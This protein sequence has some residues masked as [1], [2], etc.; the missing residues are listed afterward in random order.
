MDGF[1]EQYISSNTLALI[2]SSLIFIIT[3]TLVTKQLINFV[4]TCVLLFFAVVSGMAIANNDIVR[5]Y[6]GWEPAAAKTE[7]P[8]GESTLDNIRERISSIYEQLVEVLSNQKEDKAAPPAT[9][10]Q[11]RSSIEGLL[12]QLEDQKEQL[13]Q[14]LESQRL[15]DSSFSTNVDAN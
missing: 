4:I 7:Q 5:S 13:R 10:Q 8:A 6:L 9:K 11:L 12:N 14:F 3:V 2:V 15:N 1:F